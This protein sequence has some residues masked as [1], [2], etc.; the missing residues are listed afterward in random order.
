VLHPHH[1]INTVVDTSTRQHTSIQSSSARASTPTTKSISDWWTDSPTCTNCR[2]VFRCPVASSTKTNTPSTWDL[3][4]T[5]ARQIID[6]SEL[7]QLTLLRC[8]I[9]QEPVHFSRSKIRIKGA[10]KS[11]AD[12]ADWGRHV[13][14]LSNRV[15]IVELSMRT[16]C[17]QTHVHETPKSRSCLWNS[18][19]EPQFA[20]V[21]LLVLLASVL[22]HSADCDVWPFWSSML[23]AF[24]GCCLFSSKPLPD[25]WAWLDVRLQNKEITWC[26][27]DLRRLKVE[28][29][30][31]I[32]GFRWFFITAEVRAV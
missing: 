12:S 26:D 3:G 17:Q 9:T 10:S 8:A 19:L 23:D 25:C 4:Q 1:S 16:R 30:A 2:I 24:F 14:S 13:K 20:H 31:C 32:D 18:L 22:R 28:F 21:I 29:P 7:S 27:Y 6:T 5:L 11:L 15:T